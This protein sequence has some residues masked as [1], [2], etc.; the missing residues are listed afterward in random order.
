MAL[1]HDIIAILVHLRSFK[2]IGEGAMIYRWDIL[3]YLSITH[4]FTHTCLKMLWLKFSAKKHHKAPD[5]PEAGGMEGMAIGWKCV[6]IWPADP[7]CPWW[8]GQS[9]VC[10]CALQCK[11]I[12]DTHTHTH[13]YACGH[14]CVFVCGVY[15]CVSECVCICVSS[16]VGEI[17]ASEPGGE[18]RQAIT[19]GRGVGQSWGLGEEMWWENPTPMHT[20]IF[21][22]FHYPVFL[23]L[24]LP[25]LQT[26][27]CSFYPHVCPFLNSALFQHTLST[28]Y[29]SHCIIV[30]F[31]PFSLLPLTLR[32]AV[33]VLAMAGGS[34]QGWGC[35]SLVC[36]DRL[37]H[38]F[39]KA[40]HW[41]RR[42]SAA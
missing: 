15:I 40:V 32:R 42:P 19:H 10:L 13:E 4:H 41:W 25:L 3:W 21:L 1:N 2:G 27:L 35:C 6:Y 20:F 22:T 37:S 23:L 30:G 36:Y 39:V 14:V 12:Y 8:T 17:I 33:V 28:I 18:C 31:L 34:E 7:R 5:A 26:C 24:L 11:C 9:G 29:I 16:G 38:W